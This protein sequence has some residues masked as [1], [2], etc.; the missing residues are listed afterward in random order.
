MDY[1]TLRDCAAQVIFE[2]RLSAKRSNLQLDGIPLSPVSVQHER[3]PR[4]RKTIALVLNAVL[5]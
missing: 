2:K 5:F 3:A 1:D 4:G